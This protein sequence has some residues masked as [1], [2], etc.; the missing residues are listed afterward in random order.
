LCGT[1]Y[2]KLPKNP[3][4][5]QDQIDVHTAL[6]FIATG[7]MFGTVQNVLMTFPVERP[8]FLKEYNSNL[9]SLF[10][11]FFGRQLVDF[12]VMIF[13]PVFTSLA[14]YWSI[15]FNTLSAGNFFIFLLCMIGMALAG[16]SIGLLVGSQIPDPKAAAGSV[17]AII[18]PF[19][20]FAGIV[21]NFGD[22]GSWIKWAQYISPHRYVMETMMANEYDGSPLQKQF[23]DFY[24][25][26]LGMWESW[27]LLIGLGLMIRLL[28]Y[29]SLK[30][31]IK[32]LE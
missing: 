9:Y 32:N 23:L 25:Y 6:L 12:P 13:F 5:I 10:A 24:H 20:C 26:D 22:M 7:M 8:V 4:N 28:S 16:N 1:L 14:L 11:Y 30:R 15:G 19:L 27:L 2:F 3:D 31:M 17:N 18:I 29:I 21:K